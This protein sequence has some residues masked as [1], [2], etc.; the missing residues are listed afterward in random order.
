M[1]FLCALGLMLGT[2]RPTQKITLIGSGEND[3][4]GPLEIQLEFNDTLG[5]KI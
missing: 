2:F 1:A 4:A 5:L 3:D